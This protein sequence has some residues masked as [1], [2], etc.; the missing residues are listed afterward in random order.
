MKRKT[1]RRGGFTL[2]EL[3][4]VI[5]L[6]GIFFSFFCMVFFGNWIAYNREILQIDL[7]FEARQALAKICKHIRNSDAVTILDPQSFDILDIEKIDEETSVEKT[8]SYR[9]QQGQIIYSVDG[10]PEIVLCQN[11]DKAN[12]KFSWSGPKSIAIVITLRQ[13]E[14]I[15]TGGGVREVC[16]NLRSDVQRRNP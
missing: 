10:G 12:S 13:S 6:I 8:T 5:V 7:Q 11:I 3:I 14:G 2:I 4:V 15:F 16:V 9:I 1:D